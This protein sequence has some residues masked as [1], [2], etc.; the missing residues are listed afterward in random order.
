LRTLGSVLT[1]VARTPVNYLVTV[2]SCEPSVTMANIKSFSVFTSSSIL[3]RTPVTHVHPGLAVVPSEPLPAP[4]HVVI[5]TI[6]TGP[7]IHTGG[8]SA[9]IIISFTVATRET[10]RT[11]T[12]VGVYI[13]FAGGS[14]FAGVHLTFIN[15]LLAIFTTKPSHAHAAVVPYFVQASPSI[16]T[17]VGQAVVSIYQAISS[18]K[19]LLA[20]TSVASI[21][22]NTSGSISAGHGGGT[23]VY[24]HLAPCTLVTKRTR[25]GELLVVAIRRARGPIFTRIGCTGIHLT[26]TSFTIKWRFT[27][28]KKVIDFINTSPTMSAGLVSTVVNVNFTVDPS[29]PRRTDTAVGSNLVQAPSSVLTWVSITFIDLLAAG[30]ASPTR[31]AVA[32][33]FGHLVL[34]SSPVAR[35]VMALVPVRLTSFPVPPR[36]AATHVVIDEVCTLASIHARVGDALVDVFFTQPSPVTRLALASVSID[37]IHT[38]ALIET[39]VG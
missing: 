11:S 18:F 19:S 36:L 10:K 22:V 35:V 12:S 16:N 3:A 26:L 25:A 33:E 38:L 6:N 30:S 39:R 23:L 5:D 1:R 7:T 21:G 27:N 14:I 17:R 4:A 37:F 20:L 13:V 8:G 9:V 2:L 28:T 34:T 31:R 15:I 24:I 32:D 29:K